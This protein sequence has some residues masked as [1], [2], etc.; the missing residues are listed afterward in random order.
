[1]E[2]IALV[3]LRATTLVGLETKS[4]ELFSN[5]CSLGLFFGTLVKFV[6][7]GGLLIGLTNTKYAMRDRLSNLK[8]GGRKTRTYLF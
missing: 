4:L 5:I 2:E 8:N 3:V 6:N 1:M 7:I